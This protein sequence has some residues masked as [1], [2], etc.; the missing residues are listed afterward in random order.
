MWQP[1]QE[2]KAKI[3]GILYKNVPNPVVV[4]GSSL[5]AFSRE[6]ASNILG[7]SL[8]IFDDKG[9]LIA[10]V[11][12]NEIHN[13]KEGFIVVTGMNRFSVIRAE[14]GQVFLDL[15]CDIKGHEHEL[16]LSLLCVVQ[17]YPLVLHPERTKCGVFND[18]KAPNISRLTLLANPGSMAGGIALNNSP[19]YLLGMCIENFLNGVVIKVGQEDESA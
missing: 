9:N 4:N 6:G 3:G 16:E 14:S 17:G 13:L 19:I 8:E 12:N 15:I 18:H 10:S 2:Y 7:V 11:I 5:I 1:T